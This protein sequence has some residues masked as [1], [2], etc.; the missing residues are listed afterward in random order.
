M[1][2]H[3]WEWAI[4]SLMMWREARNQGFQGMRAV[5]HVANNRAR[6]LR[7]SIALTVCEDAQFTSINPP[8]KTYDPQ[9]DVWP[10]PD[11]IYFQ[12]AMS[13]ANEILGGTSVDPTGGASFYWNPKTANSPWF[14][15]VVANGPRFEKSATLGDHEFFR[16]KP[17]L[18]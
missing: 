8:K 3:L 13:I 17:K 15:R 6:T 5:G 16:E 7:T 4:L 11:D 1:N 10:R 12:Q 9:L 14:E 2:W 18:A